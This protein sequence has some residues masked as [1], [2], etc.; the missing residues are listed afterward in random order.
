[1]SK[2]ADSVIKKMCTNDIYH[3]GLPLIT[4]FIDHTIDEGVISYGLS[5]VGYDVRLDRKAYIFK[6]SYNQTID[7]RRFKDEEYCKKV[8]DIVEDDEVIILPP[9][10]YGLVQSHEWVNMPRQ[11]VAC[12]LGKSTYARCGLVVNTTPME[13]E[14]K[15]KLTIEL[16]NTSPCPLML[17]VMQGIAQFQF[18]LV[19]GD[20][21][22]S[23]A[24]KSKGKAGKYQDQTDVTPARIL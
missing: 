7:P 21:M 5:S 19:Y 18:E 6:N 10:S 24:D 14:W 22:K 12:C 2:L 17:F 20:V 8:F 9:H 13:P 16:A 3:N 4:P 11:L 1:M 23:Y 15:G